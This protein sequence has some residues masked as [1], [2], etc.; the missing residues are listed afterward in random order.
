M[1]LYVP[2]KLTFKNIKYY[3]FS[4]NWWKDNKWIA[5]FWKNVSLMSFLE[6]NY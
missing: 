5:T 1:L 6:K 4:L 3:Y 2:T